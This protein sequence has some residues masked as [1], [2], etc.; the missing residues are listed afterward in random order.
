MKSEASVYL[1][2]IRDMSDA[3]ERTID[4]IAAPQFN[5]RPGP[6]LNPVGWNYFH[7]LRI[8]DLDL[9]WMCKGQSPLEDAWHR[10]GFTGKSGYDPDGKGGLSTGTGYGYSDDEVDE[11]QIEPKILKEYQRM[12]MAETEEFL[13]AAGEDEM[14]SRTPSLLDPDQTRSGAERMQHTIAHSHGHIGEMR[15]A[16]GVLGWRDPSNPGRNR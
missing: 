13:R 3:L 6:Q 7:L 2:Q 16:M 14:R 1:E 15:Y 11:V 10:G 8:W 9:N 12:L 5:Q 4:E